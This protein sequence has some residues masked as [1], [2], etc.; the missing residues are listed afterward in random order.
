MKKSILT[1]L[2]LCIFALFC[3]VGG[4]V[5]LST[6]FLTDN[7]EIEE[8][9]EEADATDHYIYV[10][11]KLTGSS[12]TSAVYAKQASSDSEGFSWSGYTQLTSSYQQIFQVHGT[13]NFWS[14]YYCYFVL[15]V[16]PSTGHYHSSSSISYQESASKDTRTGSA[17]TW[18]CTAG[19]SN[20]THGYIRHTARKIGGTSHMTYYFDIYTT[21]SPYYYHSDLNI[22]NPSGTQDYE[23]G[24]CDVSYGSIASGNDIANENWDCSADIFPYGTSVSLSDIRP[25][26]GYALSDVCW[27][28]SSK[29]AKSS[30]SFTV[31]GSQN[32]EIY[33][34]WVKYTIA[35]SANGGSGSMSNTSATYGSSVNLRSL[36]FSPPTGKHFSYWS[37]SNGG[38]Y[39]DGQS[40]SNLTLTDGGTVTMTAVWANNTYTIKYDAN[41]GSG[42]MSNTSATYGSSVNLRSLGF[43][44]PTGKHFDHWSGSNGGT[45][46]NGQSVSN[47]TSTNNGTVTMSAVWAW[48]TYS[49][50]FNG[51]GA[52]SGSMSNLA[53]TYNTAKNLTSNAFSR[54][55]Y[56]FLGWATTQ[57][58]AN[59]GTVDYTDGQSVNNLTTSNGATVPLYAV[60]QLNTYTISYTLNGGSV[61]GTNPT[62]YNVNTTTFTLINPTKTGYTFSGWSGTGISGA[63]TSVTI[64]QGSTGNRA[65]TANWTPITYSVVF[66]GNGGKFYDSTDPNY[67]QTMTYGQSAN[68]TANKYEK[69]G[70][71]FDG[72]SN[73]SL[74]YDDS[75]QVINLTSTANATVTF[76]AK[77]K[78]ISW[79]TTGNTTTP[80]GS[81][82]A[83]SPYLIASAQNFAWFASQVNSGNTSIVA[84]QTVP[85]DLSAHNWDPIGDTSSHAFTGVYDGQCMTISGLNVYGKTNDGVLGLFGYVGAG[86]TITKLN[87]S[88]ADIGC[89]VTSAS[90]TRY[91]GIIAG[92][93]VSTGSNVG[94]TNCYVNG[95]ITTTSTSSKGALV[96]NNAGKIDGCYAAAEGVSVVVGTNT[97]TVTNC[98]LNRTYASFTKEELQSLSGL[99]WIGNIQ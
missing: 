5:L 90:G 93:N 84:K 1:K 67:S 47:L 95:S 34:R 10:K 4:I 96:G 75:E 85:I 68:L 43:T 65:Y 53:M 29:G 32:L 81:G 14:N 11:L 83:A 48:N 12:N 8:V 64:S 20:D 70:Y 17:V 54:T 74:S 19:K 77:W 86:A 41:G 59:S 44:A 99:F 89:G 82:T 55:G 71:S 42:S 31:T 46:S 2:F 7:T 24:T 3:C 49:I 63:S 28:G 91:E 6:D 21:C 45:Y 27:G 57:A 38:T 72:W 79:I 50:S 26:T 15:Y 92:K 73:G 61:S 40:V 33:M 22:Y 39:S 58:R 78:A 76:T 9:S 18:D 62:S 37:G 51:N 69:T 80:S 52:T 87:I 98:Y 30:Y 56:T 35:Y 60:W 97:G 94:I 36:G 25:A 88:S 16:S 66:N 23:S 13:G